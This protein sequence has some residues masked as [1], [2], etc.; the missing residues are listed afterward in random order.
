MKNYG[1]IPHLSSSYM[2]DGDHR[3]TMGQEEMLTKKRKS[4]SAQ[5]IVLEKYD[6]CNGGILKTG[7]RIVALT[8]SGN[9]ARFSPHAHL[10]LFWAW[11]RCFEKELSDL[12][13]E[14]ERL[15]VEWLALAHGTKYEI[16][17]F[18]P[19]VAIDLF[20]SNGER[21]RFSELQNRL[22]D[23]SFFAARVL[24]EGDPIEPAKLRNKLNEKTKEFQS[25]EEPEGLIYRYEEKERVF[26]LAKWVR[27][28]YEPA[29][30]WKDE[31]GKNVEVWNISDE[32]RNEIWEKALELKF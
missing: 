5:V 22:K 25:I 7:N 30:Y 28:N 21:A 20:F 23:S 12:L 10:K 18:H 17:H 13:L 2:T 19:A 4:K 1:R 26:F 32:K 9:E 31:N 8:R 14:E 15:V 3:I 29:K 11:T 16:N 6:G 24:H 27:E